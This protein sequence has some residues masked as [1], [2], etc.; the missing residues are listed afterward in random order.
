MEFLTNQRKLYKDQQKF[1]GVEHPTC[2]YY[3]TSQLD[4]IFWRDFKAL[5]EDANILRDNLNIEDF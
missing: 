4:L 2:L 3:T 1:L 5:G